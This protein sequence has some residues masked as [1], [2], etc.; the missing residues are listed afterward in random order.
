MNPAKAENRN[1]IE[2]AIDNYRKT[3]DWPRSNF[4]NGYTHDIISMIELESRIGNR[5]S[6]IRNSEL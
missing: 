3:T 2:E 6:R 4:I 1:K 5:E